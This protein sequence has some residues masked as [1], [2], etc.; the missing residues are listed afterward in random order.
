[1][2]NQIDENLHWIL[3]FYRSSEISGALFFGQLARS[4]RPGPI[5]RDMT[6]HFADE[7]QHARYWSDCLQGL[8]VGAIKLGNSYQDQY[9]MAAGMPVNLMEVLAISQVFE[10]RV[11]SHYARHSRLPEI[12]SLV[13]ETLIRIM[14]DERWH[15]QWISEALKNMEE[16]YGKSHIDATLKRFKAADEEVYRKISVEHR[17]HLAV[18]ESRSFNQGDRG[19]SCEKL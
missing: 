6:Q 19:G 15:I 17:E 18:I 11:F 16:Q 3:S 1:M 5:Q 10:K 12:D 14:T 8:G 13:H 7:A 9:I 2:A 4:M